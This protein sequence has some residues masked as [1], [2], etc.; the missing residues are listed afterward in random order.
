MMS[1]SLLATLG[2]G[3][4]GPLHVLPL[5]IYPAGMLLI[6]AAVLAAVIWILMKI[7]FRKTRP[8]PPYRPAAPPAT[9]PRDVTGKIR[10]IRSEHLKSGDYR[11]GCHVLSAEVK[12]YLESVTARQVEEMTAREITRCLGESVGL[13]FKR[14]AS[15]QF[16]EEEPSRKAF[17]KIC[18]EA[19]SVCGSAAP[20][21]WRAR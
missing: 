18:D 21:A 8:R 19:I 5:W 16:A 12:T 20:P 11:K 13:F 15:L 6:A 3:P 2:K 14:L 10:D 4:A 9:L 7:A 1:F 17:T